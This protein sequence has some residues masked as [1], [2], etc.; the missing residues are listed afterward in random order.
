M[1]MVLKALGWI[2]ARVLEICAVIA[3]GLILLLVFAVTADVVGRQFLG[4]S[5]TWVLE[6]SEAMLLY[7]PFLAM[8]WLA[9]HNGHVAIDLVV[10]TLP[11]HVRRGMAAVVSAVAAGTCATA[12]YWATLT[13]WDHYERGIMTIGLHPVPKYLLLAVIALGFALSAIEFGRK[14]L[15]LLTTGANASDHPAHGEA[16]RTR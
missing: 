1:I 14:T 3:G 9:R 7:V 11:R 2:H 8:A 13:T 16:D 5:L 6:A 12:A 10:N 15:A 4:Q